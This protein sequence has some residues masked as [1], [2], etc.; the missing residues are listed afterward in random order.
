MVHGL[1]VR[2]CVKASAIV[3]GL[4]ILIALVQSISTKEQLN[5]ERE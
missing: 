3:A 1:G 4:A 5:P 2:K